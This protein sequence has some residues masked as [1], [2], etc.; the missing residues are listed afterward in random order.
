MI[1]VFRYFF[2]KYRGNTVEDRLIL[3]L[4]LFGI[5]QYTYYLGRSHPNNLF[6]ISMAAVIIFGYWFSRVKSN[7][8]IPALLR[9]TSRL[10]FF[11]T[12]ITIMLASYAAFNYKYQGVHT[13]LTL[14]SHISPDLLNS[15][16]IHKWLS[17]QKAQLVSG[18]QD[19]QVAEAHQLIK[20]YMPGQKEIPIFLT[21]ENTTEILFTTG[22]T[23]V[24]PIGDIAQELGSASNVKRI[25]DYPSPLKVGDYMLIEKNPATY[26]DTG[27]YKLVVMLLDRIC[28]QFSFD[29]IESSYHGVLVVR[30]KPH[31]DSSQSYCE[32]INKI[33]Q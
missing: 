14:F 2:L 5:A 19:H 13:G 27:Y 4:T 23:H 33:N 28:H 26:D 9:F 32:I 6:H 24:F 20:K 25:M 1:F 15:E 22:R 8:S 30:L 29:E 31:D 12:A 18:S 7:S 16:A 21:Y 10:V 17:S 11:S 3:G